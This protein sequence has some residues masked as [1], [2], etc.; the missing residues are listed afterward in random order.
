M[1]RVKCNVCGR[2][3]KTENGLLMEDAFEA[4][5]DWGFFSRKDMQ[6]H[7][8]TVCEDCYDA[9]IKSFAIPPQVTEKTE[10]L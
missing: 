9:W 8:F 10:A 1:E 4:V 6:R 2:G 3:L 7:S 5:K